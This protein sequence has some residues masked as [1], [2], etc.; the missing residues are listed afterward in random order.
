MKSDVATTTAGACSSAAVS[1]RASIAAAPA[2]PSQPTHTGA[3][4]TGR[5]LPRTCCRKHS[6]FSIECS[7]LRVA[8]E[9]GAAQGAWDYAAKLHCLRAA[10]AEAEAASWFMAEIRQGKSADGLHAQARP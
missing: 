10:E 7:R 3:M 9:G 5:Q 8:A 4:L 6:W 1:C 2:L